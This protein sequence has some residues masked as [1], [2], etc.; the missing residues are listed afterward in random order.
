MFRAMGEL[1]AGNECL[2]AKAAA[3]QAAPEAAAAR[4]TEAGPGGCAVTGLFDPARFVA[5]LSA[6]LAAAVD[7]RDAAGHSDG[8]GGGGGGELDDGEGRGPHIVLAASGG[9][10]ARGAPFLAEQ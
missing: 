8:G 3:A 4:K 1:R 2:A 6:L 7:A 9:G 5:E 10:Y